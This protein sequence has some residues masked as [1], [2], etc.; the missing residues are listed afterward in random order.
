MQELETLE[1]SLV[2]QVATIKLNR[3]STMNAISQKMRQELLLLMEEVEVS[4][5]VK[6]VLLSATGRGFSSGGDLAE[7]LAGYDTVAD[8]ILAE[9]IPLFNAIQHS[10][11]LYVAAIHGP[12][13]GIASGLAMACDLAIMAENSYWYV[14]FS[15][16]NLVPD[17]G[18]SYQL[19]RHLG[20]KKAL[21]LFLNGAKISAQDCE[22]MGVVNK[23][24]ADDMLQEAAKEW[25]KKLAKGAP[26]S[27]ALGKQCLQYAMHHTLNETVEFEALH[28]TT[29]SKSP[30]TLA[31]VKAMLNKEKPVFS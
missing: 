24:V 1:F 17:G 18:V 25:A 21:E 6:V 23:V 9:Y 26:L 16:L 28:Q 4:T 3:P 31:A 2:N 5:Q 7:G 20:Y 15:G 22:N 8:K 30:D 14:P 19:V 27:H 12:C 10:K 11:K 29:C 13:T